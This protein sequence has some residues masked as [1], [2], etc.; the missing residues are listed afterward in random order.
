MP[1]PAR[2]RLDDGC[3]G[4]E[5]ERGKR[6][7]DQSQEGHLHFR[8]PDLLANIF[9]GAADHEAGQKD[10][11]NAEQQH[12]EEAGAGRAHDHFVDHHVCEQNAAAQRHEAV[13]HTV[14][15]A[16]RGRG[17]D[18][19][20]ERGRG[21]AE[22]HF[23]AFHVSG[24]NFLS[25][26]RLGLHKGERRIAACFQ[27]VNGADAEGEQ[28]RHDRE[29]RPPLTFGT[30]HAPKAVGQGRA[31]HQDQQQFRKVGQRTGILEWMRGIGVEEA[32]AVA[33]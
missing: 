7:S 29:K 2:A 13:M 28:D 8:R 15:G 14:D 31:K 24:S 9:R 33:A 19:R 23:L 22:T 21:N 6:H 1:S 25:G 5:A 16:V 12:A 18:I 11:D 30:D 26:V 27:R 32:A 20:E 10:G 17:R 4:G 3:D